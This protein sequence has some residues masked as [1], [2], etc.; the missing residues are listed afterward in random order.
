METGRKDESEQKQQNIGPK[1]DPLCLWITRKCCDIIR[2]CW[3]YFWFGGLNPEAR[4]AGWVA[5]LTLLLFIVGAFQAYA[6]I[7]SERAFVYQWTN[8]VS[9]HPLSAGAPIAVTVNV[10]NSGR[11]SAFI[12]DMNL[13]YLFLT[14]PLPI[15]PHYVGGG[16]NA[17]SGP[18]PPGTIFKAI[19]TLQ[20]HTGDL[21]PNQSVDAVNNGTLRFYIFGWVQYTDAFSWLGP[22]ITGYCGVYVPTAQPDSDF[23]NCGRP[24]Y[25][26]AR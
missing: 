13:T 11:L 18:V 5:R 26:Y 9:P 1:K 21:V 6:F 3:N 19:V 17:V 12:T 15:D 8:F 16:V 4:F 25:I 14:D 10:H 7:T 22:K 23:N 20:T 24:N 2:S